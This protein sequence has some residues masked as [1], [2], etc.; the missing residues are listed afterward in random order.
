MKRALAIALLAG[1]F[2]I[3]AYAES[4]PDHETE[5][6]SPAVGQS[7]A[8]TPDPDVATIACFRYH[9]DDNL[10]G[11]RFTPTARYDY[12][13]GAWVQ[14]PDDYVHP[15]GNRPPLGSELLQDANEQED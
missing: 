11:C 6:T 8:S 9:E 14:V 4:R 3:G 15:N 13:A 5:E 10:S 12:V 2:T 7:T 1:A